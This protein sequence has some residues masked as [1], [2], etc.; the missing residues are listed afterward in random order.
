MKLLSNNLEN[1]LL[2]IRNSNQRGFTLAEVLISLLIFSII[3]LVLYTIVNQQI[4]KG[5]ESISH[6]EQIDNEVHE[7]LEDIERTMLNQVRGDERIVFDQLSG[8]EFNYIQN[9]HKNNSSRKLVKVAY[10]VSKEGLEKGVVREG[11]NT[12]DW[13][14]IHKGVS[15]LLIDYNLGEGGLFLGYYRVKLILSGQVYE[16]VV[17]GFK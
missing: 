9:S 6:N 1:Q 16:R 14:L 13:V 12:Y 11:S 5:V 10:R 7:V 3:S 15:S 8:Y 4:V 17:R 2:R